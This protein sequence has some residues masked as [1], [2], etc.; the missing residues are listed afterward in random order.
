[1]ATGWLETIQVEGRGEH[2]G[3]TTDE[4]DISGD[5]T[6]MAGLSIP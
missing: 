1:M 4:Q 3:R 6:A 5:G 2:F